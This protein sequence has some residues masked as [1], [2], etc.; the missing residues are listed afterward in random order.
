MVENLAEV[1]LFFI[2]LFFLVEEKKTKKKKLLLMSFDGQ[3]FK[4]IHRRS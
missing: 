3:G 2:F 4:I 1:S